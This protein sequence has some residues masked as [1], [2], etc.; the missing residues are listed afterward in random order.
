MSFLALLIALLMWNFWPKSAV[1]QNDN[2]LQPLYKMLRSLLPTTL[3][4]ALTI[5]LPVIIVAGF[6]LLLEHELFGLLT[7]LFSVFVVIYGLGRGDLRLAWLAYVDEWQRGNYEAAY[8]QAIDLGVITAD[9]VIE[10]SFTLHQ[11]MRGQY[12]Y[13]GLE[14]WFAP[15]FWFMV[16]GPAA[17]VG[18]RIVVTITQ[19]QGDEMLTTRQLAARC[20]VWLEFL[21]ARLLAL[22]FA[23]AANFSSAFTYFQD[24][25]FAQYPANTL[26]AESAAKALELP[27]TLAEYVSTVEFID[28]ST[29]ELREMKS[30]LK[31]SQI[32]WILVLGFMLLV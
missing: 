2:W 1:V 3:A 23:L 22:T 15:I 30:L 27:N 7:L 4:L 13:Y 14:R 10:D 19:W 16:L 17:I 21:P 12:C 31:R 24:K 8:Q 6:F 9:D 28:A 32:V 18:Y 20:C 26:V 11:R 5:A 29:Q 25:L